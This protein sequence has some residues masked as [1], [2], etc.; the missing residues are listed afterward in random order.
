MMKKCI[1]SPL[2]IQLQIMNK[3]V[4]IILLNLFIS[5]C[6]QFSGDENLKIIYYPDS[7]VIKQSVEYKNKKKNGLFRAYYRNGNPKAVQHYKNDTLTDT[8]CFYHEN[9]KLASYQIFDR[10]IK[11]GR[12]RKFN[13]D[14]REYWN[15]GFKHGSL[16]GLAE[17]YSYKSIKLMCRKNYE[18]GR[19]SGKQEYFHTDGKPKSVVYFID[20]YAAMGTREWTPSGNEINNDFKI[21][22]AE[23]NEV[24]LQGKLFFYISLQGLQAGDEVYEISPRDTGN[25]ISTLRHLIKEGG[26]YVIEYY[27]PKGGFIME[28]VH[29]AAYRKTGYGNIF[30]KKTKFMASA[31][32][33]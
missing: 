32:N 22:V 33:F 17:E 10:G 28:E 11:T 6:E 18:N 21:T 27:I 29:L 24:L 23:K 15:A 20:G 31:N 25:K 26:H 16:D 19:E 12:W 3:L 1:L 14:G 2:I 9:G 4:G 7:E 30:I 8:S 5:S 13:K